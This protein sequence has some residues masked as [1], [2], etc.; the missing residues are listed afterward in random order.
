MPGACFYTVAPRTG[1]PG[2][3][4]LCLGKTGKFDLQ[5]LSQGCTSNCLCRSVPEIIF[6]CCRDIQQPVSNNY[7]AKL[8]V[9]KSMSVPCIMNVQMAWCIAAG[10]GHV[11]LRNGT[12][13]ST[14][15]SF[16]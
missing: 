9:D 14:S 10:M 11:L 15:L 13:F 7:A 4:I 16:F 6:A 8:S 5:N 1:W 2:V 3:S 12:C